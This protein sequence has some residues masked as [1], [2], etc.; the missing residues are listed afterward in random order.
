ME[1]E[2]NLLRILIFLIVPKLQQL[3]CT[4]VSVICKFECHSLKRKKKTSW[5]LGFSQ[6]FFSSVFIP[7][8]NLQH[9]F[10]FANFSDLIKRERPMSF[11]EEH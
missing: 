6:N 2:T 11:T 8:L 4:N 10:S 1:E 7:M 5:S 9:F 3:C